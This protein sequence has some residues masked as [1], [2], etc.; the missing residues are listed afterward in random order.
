MSTTRLLILGVLCA[1]P[2]HGYEV[3]RELELW[4]AQRWANIAY[5]SIYFGLK[6][7]ADEGL[8][9]VTGTEEAGGRAARTVYAATEAGRIE[10]HRL[11]TEHWWREPGVKDPFL[12]ALTFMP[13]MSTEDLL[14]ALRNRA[15]LLTARLEMQRYLVAPKEKHGG[16]HIGEVMR[17]MA[18]H[19]EAELTWITDVVGKVERG[20]LP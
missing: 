19:T 15:A 17:F 10:F 9:E 3:R 2:M 16:A 18:V 12:A 14:A 1:R 13:S 5:G 4:Q 20:E 8:V 6:K 11:L 7:M